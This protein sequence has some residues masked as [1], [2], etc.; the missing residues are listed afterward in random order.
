MRISKA[1]Y[2]IIEIQHSQN[3]NIIETNNQQ[4]LNNHTTL[5]AAFRFRTNNTGKALSKR[6]NFKLHNEIN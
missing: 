2:K 5:P 3:S 6:F 4:F 1:G